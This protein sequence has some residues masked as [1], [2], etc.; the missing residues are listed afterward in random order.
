MEGELL[1]VPAL[2]SAHEA[3]HVVAP[4]VVLAAAV[5]V[6]AAAVAVLAVVQRID[7]WEPHSPHPF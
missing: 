1:A 6:L 7:P 3:A 4:V 2:L 5:A